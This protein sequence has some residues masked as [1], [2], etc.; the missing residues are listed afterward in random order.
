MSE[1]VDIPYTVELENWI[2]HKIK[3]SKR[4]IKF[5]PNIGSSSGNGLRKKT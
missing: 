3:H 4:N 1:K 2:S 5:R